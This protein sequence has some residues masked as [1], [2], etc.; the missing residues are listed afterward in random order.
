MQRRTWGQY[1]RSYPTYV[2]VN[3]DTGEVYAG[4]TSGFD[5]PLE[6][7]AARDTSCAYDDLGFGPAQLDQSSASYLW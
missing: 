6:N 1:S 2:K 7:I 5:T 4:R 3:A